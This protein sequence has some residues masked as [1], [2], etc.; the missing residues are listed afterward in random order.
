MKT[1]LL[2]LTC[3]ILAGIC[4]FQQWLFHRP[5]VDERVPAAPTWDLKLLGHNIKHPS[6][7][8][9]S[10][11]RRDTRTLSA[12]SYGSYAFDGC[13]WLDVSG[14]QFRG[15]ASELR[16]AR[17]AAIA[18]HYA[19][20]IASIIPGAIVFGGIEQEGMEESGTLHSVYLVKHPHGQIAISAGYTNRDGSLSDNV[21]VNVLSCGSN[22]SPRRVLDIDNRF[23]KQDG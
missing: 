13:L 12:T 15:R 10:S 18:A 17:I 5:V 23:V 21:K 11:P 14:I 2:I 1:K 4:L 8:Q 16:E 3:V 6:G 22:G 7:A 9:S 19:H 20:Q